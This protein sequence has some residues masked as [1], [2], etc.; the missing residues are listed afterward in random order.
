MCGALTLCPEEVLHKSTL[1][2][3]IYRDVVW[4]TAG[5]ADIVREET[6]AYA[7]GRELDAA[8]AYLAEFAPTE[9]R[10][11]FEAKVSSLFETKW[12]VDL[13]DTAMLRVYDYPGGGKLYFDILSKSYMAAFPYSEPE[14]LETFSLERSAF[15]ERKREA[16]LL[17][18]IA[19]WGYA[20]PELKDIFCQGEISDK[21]PTESRQ[22]TDNIRTDFGLSRCYAM[23]GG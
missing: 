14:L 21:I 7:Y 1:V 10:Q 6:A 23:Y 15:Y 16:T 2:M 9:R 11:D 8:L 22:Y 12:L 13:I 18:G 5:R 20:I 19:L 17:L 3:R 4:M